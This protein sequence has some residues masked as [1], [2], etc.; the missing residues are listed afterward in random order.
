MKMIKKT[1]AL[2]TMAAL[3]VMPTA[4]FGATEQEA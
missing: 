2:A 1:L 4:S 3:L